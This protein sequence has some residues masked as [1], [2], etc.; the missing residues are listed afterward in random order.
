LLRAQGSASS[1]SL[2]LVETFASLLNL[3]LFRFR[4]EGESSMDHKVGK[5]IT[6]V[7]SR[8]NLND[9]KAIVRQ[10]AG[11]GRP[12][13]LHLLSADGGVSAVIQNP[14]TFWK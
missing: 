13:L 3:S 10:E 7:A 1:I 5:D 9:K 8:F 11:I 2:F 12:P 4:I 14:A 6:S